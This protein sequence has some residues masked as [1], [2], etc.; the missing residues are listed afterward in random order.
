MQGEGLADCF[1][2]LLLPS[3]KEGEQSA[4]SDVAVSERRPVVRVGGEFLRQLLKDRDRL[5]IGLLRLIL[6]VQVQTNI[7]Y[8]AP[9]I[10]GL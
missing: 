8:P 4:Q 6:L 9:G 7:S 3:Q 10:P 5:L 1:L 2:G